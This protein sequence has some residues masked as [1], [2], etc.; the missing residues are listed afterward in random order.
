V[1][2]DIL[3]IQGKYF[4][5]LDLSNKKVEIDADRSKQFCRTVPD[6]VEFDFGNNWAEAVEMRLR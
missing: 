4:K 5:S 6:A 1:L 2:Y 3:A